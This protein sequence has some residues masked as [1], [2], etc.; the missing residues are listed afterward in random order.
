MD[1][2]STIRNIPSLRNA[3]DNMVYALIAA[4]V[5]VGV[6]ILFVIIL[7]IIGHSAGE[8]RNKEEKAPP[9]H[10]VIL[11]LKDALVQEMRGTS[12]QNT[13]MI[14]L[15]VFFIVISVIGILVTVFGPG[16][17][18]NITKKVMTNFVH[19]TKAVEPAVGK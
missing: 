3:P 6:F 19:T 12:R 16:M 5:V 7:L 17:V 9:T 10:K 15:T 11:E 8:N 4:L 13:I 1:I 2:L 18:T 14:W